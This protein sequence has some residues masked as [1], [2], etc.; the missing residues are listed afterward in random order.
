MTKRRDAEL[1]LGCFVTEAMSHRLVRVDL[2]GSNGWAYG[3]DC[4][5]QRHIVQRP[6]VLEGESPARYIRRHCLQTQAR[7]II[8]TDLWPDVRAELIE[9]ALASSADAFCL[10]L[11]SA[12]GEWEE[13]CARVT[14]V[15]PA[16]A[17]AVGCGK[18]DY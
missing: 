4:R 12:R 13:F 11:I 2:I 17:V 5:Q 8:A 1:T 6:Y 10:G 9:I 18:G 15:A 14:T 7:D 16:D 3:V